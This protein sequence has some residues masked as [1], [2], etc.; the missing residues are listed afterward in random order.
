MKSLFVP[1]CR[2]LVKG[3]RGGLNGSEGNFS[4]RVERRGSND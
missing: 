2:C 4:G 3:A 1:C